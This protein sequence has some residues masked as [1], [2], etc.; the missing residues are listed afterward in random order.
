[1]SISSPS[2][3][4]SASTTAAGR[5]TARLLPHLA[6]C[7]PTSYG[8]TLAIM[9][10]LK[11]RCQGTVRGLRAMEEP[12]RRARRY[13]LP[14]AERRW[15]K[16]LSNTE[17][18]VIATTCERFIAETLRPR[19]LPEIRPTAFNYPIDIFGKWRGS[20]YS[21]ITR[22]RSGFPDKIGRAHV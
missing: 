15:V 6:T 5:R 13:E 2:V 16:V 1:M 21:F 10:I 17:K 22:Y 14:R 11:W 3:S 7:M 8:Y 12:M 19:S 9:Y 4:S 18:A 20:K